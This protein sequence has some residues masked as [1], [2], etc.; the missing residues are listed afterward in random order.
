MKVLGVYGGVGSMMIG[1]KQQGWEVI[2]NIEERPYY[3]TG[4][5]EAN[6]P[7][8]WMVNSFDALTEEQRAQAMECDMIIGHPDCGSFSALRQ[9]TG[10]FESDRERISN[11]IKKFIQSIK[12][13]QPKVFAMDD[14]PGAMKAV[15]WEIYHELLPDYD[16]YFEWINNHGYGNIQKNRKRLFVIGAKKELNYVF[17]PG[18]FEHNETI[19]ERLA[20]ISPDAKNNVQFADDSRVAGWGKHEVDE[21]YFGLK[22]KDDYINFAEFREYVAKQPIGCFRCFNR[23]G[24]MTTRLGKAKI[25]VNKPSPVITGG[26]AQGHHYL[27]RNDT[28]MPFTI[29]E[30]A[31]IQGCPDDFVFIPEM[32]PEGSNHTY[33]NLVRQTGKFMPVEFCTFIT[34]QFTDLLNGEYSPEKY[35]CKRVINS[36]PTIN[37]S[38]YEYC[39]HVGYTDQENACKFCG[40]ARYCKSQQIKEFNKRQ[41]EIAF[42]DCNDDCSDDCNK[43]CE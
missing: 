37:E 18:E 21:R 5:F 31:K 17:I 20:K 16:V 40:S 39:K 36:N 34:Q 6:F 13:F 11:D 43:E 29:R 35:T 7:G 23:S 30:R 19:L 41:Q 27:F 42:D 26:G 3:F 4:T 1:A 12:E 22:G 32:I 9:K 33:G 28:F 24:N 25:D 10:G 15:G 8:A 2:G 14:L 38:K